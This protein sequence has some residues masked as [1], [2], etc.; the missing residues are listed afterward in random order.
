MFRLPKKLKNNEINHL[1]KNVGKLLYEHFFSNNNPGL[2]CSATLTVD[3][4]FDYFI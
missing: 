3:N 4:S 1:Y 2:L